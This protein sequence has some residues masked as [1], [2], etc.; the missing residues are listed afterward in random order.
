M[1]RTNG[2]TLRNFGSIVVMLVVAGCGAPQKPVESLPPG[3]AYLVQAPVGR[4]FEA[5]VEEA[6]VAGK[7]RQSLIL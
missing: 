1:R 3:M 2:F 5:F 4:D 6:T 7:M